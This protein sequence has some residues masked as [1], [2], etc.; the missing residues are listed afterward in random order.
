VPVVFAFALCGL[1]ICAEHAQAQETEGKRFIHTV[2]GG[3]LLVEGLIAANAGLAA[4]DPVAYGVVGALLF[5]LAGAESPGSATTR[6]V[7]LAA[8]ESLAIYHIAALDKGDNSNGEIFRSSFASW[9][10]FA[11]VLATTM[12]LDGDLRRTGKEEDKTVAVRFEPRYDGA[13]FRVT[14]AF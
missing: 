9:H 11:G 8:A 2:P 10:V 5:P 4:L 1:L 12:W 6:W 14:Y 7:G 13:L 3:I